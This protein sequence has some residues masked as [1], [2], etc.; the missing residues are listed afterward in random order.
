MDG[1]LFV[2]PPRGED[3]DFHMRYLNADGGE[4]EM[5]GNGARA[6]LHFVSRELKVIPRKD[7]YQFSTQKGVYWGKGS[8]NFPVQMTEIY[9][10]NKFNVSDLF[11]SS[12][13][14]YLNTGV[15]HTIFEVDFL[16]EVDLQKIGSEIRYNPRFE[17]GV[18]VNFF[19][20]IKP[21]EV[22][23]RTY[24]RGVEG[25]TL[26][27]GTGATAVALSLAKERGW[28][29]P[30]KVHVPGGELSISFDCDFEKVYLEG[31]VDLLERSS[32][33]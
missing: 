12:F 16:K 23:M 21:N 15:P 10:W 7:S 24:E 3:F 28:D 14:Y 31:P 27:C 13:S 32:L 1:L 17:K 5:C 20:V 6:I 22:S 8:E 19:K 11:S 30:I 26:S 9:D 29:S 4:V 25:E 2:E 33:A 18:N